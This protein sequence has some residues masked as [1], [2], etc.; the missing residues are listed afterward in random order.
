[1]MDLQ[2]RR[3]LLKCNDNPDVRLDY[4][5]FIEGH[6]AGTQVTRTT[7]LLRYVPDRM[8]LDTHAFGTYL[9]TISTLNLDT[10]EDIAVTILSD[11]TNEMIPRWAQVEVHAP[12]MQH[13]AVD[14]HGVVLEERQPNWD[15]PG[16]LGRLKR[17]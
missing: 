4:L 3:R 7:I 16:L 10:P 6:L 2:S 13:D 12:D 9:D 17:L 5:V 1:M 8:I 14:V 11:I 15:N